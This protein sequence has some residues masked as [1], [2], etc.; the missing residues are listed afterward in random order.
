MALQKMTKNSLGGKTKLVCPT[1]KYSGS[2][3]PKDTGTSKALHSGLVPSGTPILVCLTF[4]EA[5]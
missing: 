3:L 2:G 5:R 4:A 1:S